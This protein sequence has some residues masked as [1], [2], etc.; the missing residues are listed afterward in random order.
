MATIRIRKRGKTFS[1]S[2]DAGKHPATGK[3]RTIER[4]GFSTKQEAF[5]AGAAAYAAWKTGDIG[6]TSERVPLGEYL[7]AWLENVA[8]RKIK[9]SSYASYAITIRSHIA[10]YI[11]GIV[12]QELRPRHVDSWLMQ[13]AGKGLA[14]GTIALARAVL[15]TALKY[16][17]YPAEL[18][19]SNPCAGMAIPRNAPAKVVRRSII[20]KEQ[21]RELLSLHPEGSKYYM[22]LMI[23]YHTGAR[24]GE[25][26]GLTWESVDLEK[27]TLTIERQIVERQAGGYAFATPKT[28]TST[29]TLFIDGRLIAALRRWKALQVERELAMGKAYQVV[30]ELA[31]GTLYTAPKMEKPPEGAILRPLICTDRYGLPVTYRGISTMLNRRGINAHS[32]RHTHATQLIEAGAKPV[33]VAARLGHK[34]ATIT[35]NLYA[36]DTEEMQK[37]TV[38]IF[39]RIVGT[40]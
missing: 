37:E 16:A 2:F 3:R 6:I 39:S 11:G 20:T 30:Y 7:A 24:I 27:G 18:I 19:R 36:H 14:R 12:L 26:F 29:R 22:P 33:D 10:P 34:D 13:L 32:F 25:V 40:L 9:L 23:L 15:S 4:G 28:A 1:F 38:A 31:G 21:F 8:K 17:V 5:D 35:Q